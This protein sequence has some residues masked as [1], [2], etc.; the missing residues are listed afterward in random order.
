MVCMDERKSHAVTPCQHQCVCEACAQQLLR[1]GAQ[2][3]PVCRGPIQRTTVYIA[4]AA[5]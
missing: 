3:C 1:Q 5:V 2:S 4:A